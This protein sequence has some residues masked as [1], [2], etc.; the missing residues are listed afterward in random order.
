MILPGHG[1]FLGK[2]VGTVPY[3]LSRPSLNAFLI[4]VRKTFCFLLLFSAA[5]YHEPRWYFAIAVYLVRVIDT[6]SY[7]LCQYVCHECF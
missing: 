6:G 2:S 3:G 5:E 1:R 4:S 7:Q